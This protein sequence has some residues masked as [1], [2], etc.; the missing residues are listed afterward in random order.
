MF[1]ACSYILGFPRGK[2]PWCVT[3]VPI[4]CPSPAAPIRNVLCTAVPIYWASPGVTNPPWDVPGGSRRP[5][6]ATGGSRTVSYT[7]LTLP[8]ILLV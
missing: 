1:Y 7:H 5:Q 4:D 3:C 8:T 6:E 2:I